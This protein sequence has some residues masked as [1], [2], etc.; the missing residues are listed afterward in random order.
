MVVDSLLDT[1]DQLAPASPCDEVRTVRVDLSEVGILDL[2]A[3]EE[4]DLFSDG[5]A[6]MRDFLAD[7]SFEDYRARCRPEGSS[8]DGVGDAGAEL[9]GEPSDA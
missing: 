9:S 1:S 3:D 6:A 8:A 7:F 4:Y 2:D 5:Y